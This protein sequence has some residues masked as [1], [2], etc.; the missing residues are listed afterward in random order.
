MAKHDEISYIETVA[1]VHDLEVSEFVR[2]LTDKPFSDPNGA[3]YLI[4]LSQ[5]IKLLPQ[6]PA[7]VLDLGVGP[8]W[9]SRIFAQFG[10][11]VVGLDISPQMIEIA[12]EKIGALPLSF[13][14]H[15]IENPL[16]H[17]HFDCAVF[18]DSLH[19][20][21]DERKALGNVFD[22]LK[23]GAIL[24]IMEPGRG[25]SKS[26]GAIE[27]TRKYGTTERDMPLSELKP[28]LR[29]A[30]FRELEQYV[31]LTSLP[32]FDLTA[33]TQKFKQLQYCAGLMYE[34]CKNGL[35][36]LIVARK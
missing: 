8:G 16:D 32:L 19:H 6:K 28:I 12:G 36:S 13:H 35:T 7:R 9:T 21:E 2:Y 31:R 10:Y 27:A 4:D 26:P 5:I 17:G 11:E 14:V 15:D 23:P 29:E 34:I 25:H 1:R 22:A 30:G 20:C 3:D 33:T 24:L 18:Y